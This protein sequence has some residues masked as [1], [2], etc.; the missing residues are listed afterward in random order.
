MFQGLESVK[1][2]NLNNNNIISIEAGTFAN[3]KN[4]E[5]LY[6][7]NNELTTVSLEMFGCDGNHPKKLEMLDPREPIVL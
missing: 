6:I 5:G 2:I 4:I 3:L 7:P 1:S